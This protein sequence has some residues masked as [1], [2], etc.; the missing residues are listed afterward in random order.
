MFV[1]GVSKRSSGVFVPKDGGNEIKYDFVKLHVRYEFGV[2][3]DVPEMS[4]GDAVDI[5]KVNTGVWS[6]F[7]NTNSMIEP[8]VLGAS[9]SLL[10]NKWGK[11]SGLSL[12]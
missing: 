9:V 3:S 8:E 5:I 6:Q 1:L 12:R 10:Y 11:V 7:L 4:A 2:D